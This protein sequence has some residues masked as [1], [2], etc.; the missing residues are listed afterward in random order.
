MVDTIQDSSGSSTEDEVPEGPCYC[1]G[2][3]GL[4]V[5]NR[6]RPHDALDLNP[7]VC[8]LLHRLREL[9]YRLHLKKPQDWVLIWDGRKNV[10]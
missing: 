8:R 1:C 9:S 7:F 2:K 10:A 3:Q 5:C 4:A 6:C